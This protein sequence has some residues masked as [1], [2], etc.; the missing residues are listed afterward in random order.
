M[1]VR[2]NRTRWIDEIRIIAG[3]R[4][5]VLAPNRKVMDIM[6]AFCLIFVMADVVINDDAFELYCAC[7]PV[8]AVHLWSLLVESKIY[9]FIYIFI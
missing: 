3:A 4:G 2:A 1:E 5:S 9:S 6:K 8:T 7:V